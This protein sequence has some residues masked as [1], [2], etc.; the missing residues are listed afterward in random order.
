MAKK[1]GQNIIRKGNDGRLNPSPGTVKTAKCG[2]CDKQMKVKRNVF[3]AT[4]FVE[5]IGGGKHLHD[6][7]IC[8]DITK[9]WHRRILS[10]RNEARDT[11]SNRIKKILEEE[12]LE[13]L[14][15]HAVR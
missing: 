11:K 15:A 13:I 14:Q 1:A 12:I 6:S 10:L 2:I 3:S 8:P 5:A 7:F 9:S 4:G